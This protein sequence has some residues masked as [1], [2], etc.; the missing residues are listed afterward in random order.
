M[1]VARPAIRTAGNVPR[2]SSDDVA[3]SGADIDARTERWIRHLLGDDICHLDAVRAGENDVLAAAA[4]ER[5]PGER[6][7]AVL[8]HGFF[9]A[10]VATIARV[11]IDNY[12]PVA[13]HT[14]V[15]FRHAQAK[16]QLEDAGV[17][18]RGVAAVRSVSLDGMLRRFPAQP[19]A[20]THRLAVMGNWPVQR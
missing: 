14:E 17:G 18:R 11:D 9:E 4:G 19:A 20:G 2:A 15:R 13:M 1:M 10:P 16:P 12:Q 8:G 3:A 5:A 6:H 7:L